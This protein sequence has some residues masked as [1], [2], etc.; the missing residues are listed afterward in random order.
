MMIN[1]LKLSLIHGIERVTNNTRLTA[2]QAVDLIGSIL[3][4][5]DK[6]APQEVSDGYHTF[7]EL[8]GIR[9][10]LSLGAFGWLKSMGWHVEAVTGEHSDGSKMYDGWFMLGATD[11]INQVTF[12]LPLLYLNAAEAFA[13]KVEKPSFVYDGHTTADVMITLAS[14]IDVV[15]ANRIRSEHGVPDRQVCTSLGIGSLVD[16]AINAEYNREFMPDIHH[17]D[18]VLKNASLGFVGGP[19][20]YAYAYNAVRDDAR[21]AF[22]NFESGLVLF[23][24]VGDVKKVDSLSLLDHPYDLPF[25][26]KSILKGYMSYRSIELKDDAT[27]RML[28]TV[29]F[30]D[31][32]KDRVGNDKVPCV[33]VATYGDGDWYEL[34]LN[35]NEVPDTT[36]GEDLIDGGSRLVQPETVSYETGMDENHYEVND[37]DKDISHSGADVPVIRG[38]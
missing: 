19:V 26:A 35:Q 30:L 15:L 36:Q 12:H 6:D 2:A 32:H 9:H 28:P 33:Y 27:V 29:C 14:M 5:S 20:S 38:K 17:L 25:Y 4:L 7:K 18:V 13:V 34:F 11:G 8:Y 23:G 31:L 24:Y 21:R 22:V 1:E 37:G 10:V 16:Q 3:E